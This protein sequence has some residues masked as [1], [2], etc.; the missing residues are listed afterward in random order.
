MKTRAKG[1]RER[2]LKK[3]TRLQAGNVTFPRAMSAMPKLFGMVSIESDNLE[4]LMTQELQKSELLFTLKW[5]P[6]NPLVLHKLHVRVAPQAEWHNVLDNVIAGNDGEITV[7]LGRFEQGAKLFIRFGVNALA[8]ILK[9]ATFIVEDR[10]K[11]TK[12]SPPGSEFQKIDQGTIWENKDE[13]DPY[14]VGG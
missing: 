13:G 6:K 10:V 14:Q 7:G 11:V 12:L 4:L 1:Y 3:S 5:A 2:S 9:A 8:E